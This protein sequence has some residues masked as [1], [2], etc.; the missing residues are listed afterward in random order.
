MYSKREKQ[1]DRERERLSKLIF[2][3]R[4]LVCFGSV[5]VFP[6]SFHM[7]PHHF[8]LWTLA[9]DSSLCCPV[10]APIFG[11]GHALRGA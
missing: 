6:Y 4:Y 2:L 10:Q 1:R 11:L 5:L 9:P 3:M 8:S 7:I